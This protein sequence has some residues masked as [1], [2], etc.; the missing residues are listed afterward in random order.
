M[1]SKALKTQ[2]NRPMTVEHQ[3][4]RLPL[5]HWGKKAHSLLEQNLRKSVVGADF[6]T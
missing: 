3:A 5:I 6:H 2:K 4:I 1:F